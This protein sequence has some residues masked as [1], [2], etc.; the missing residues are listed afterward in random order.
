[1]EDTMRLWLVLLPGCVEVLLQ[2]PREDHDPETTPA[3]WSSLAE[4]ARVDLLDGTLS[5]LGLDGYDGDRLVWSER[6]TDLDGLPDWTLSHSYSEAGLRSEEDFGADGLIDSILIY[7][8]EGRLLSADGPEGLLWQYHDAAGLLVR[9]E[10]DLDRDNLLDSVI[11]HL[12]DADGLLIEQHTDELADG[13]IDSGWLYG[14]DDQHRLVSARLDLGWDGATEG[15]SLTTYT[16]PVL[17]IGST[18]HH[19]PDLDAIEHFE[20]DAGG[21][22]LYLAV[23][24]GSDGVLDSETSYGWDPHGLLQTLELH[25]A[26]LPVYL[27]RTYVRDEQQR[28]VSERLEWLDPATGALF[29][30]HEDSWTFGGTCP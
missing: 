3:S 1:M 22:L 13:S 17:H 5:Q 12:Y 19:L 11:E 29:S 21:M 26:D 7:D 16:D 9:V 25:Q 27:R 8:G 18:E 2:T 10:Q 23:D 15:E 4:H 14:Y 6:D 24:D 28:L 30:G 20:H